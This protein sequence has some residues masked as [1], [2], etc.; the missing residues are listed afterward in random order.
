MGDSNTKQGILL[1]SGTNEVEIIE[2]YL[3]TQSF[4]VNVAKV[5][6]IVQFEDRLLTQVPKTHDAAIGSFQHR[7]S[8]IP[9][10]DLNLALERATDENEQRKLVLI[11][12][13]NRNIS[14]FL[15]DGVN[16][17]HRISWEQLQP[18]SSI[19]VHQKVPVIGS[20]RVDGREVL[21]LD[22]EEIL[23]E[24]SPGT[25]F[26]GYEDTLSQMAKNETAEDKELK[27]IIVEDSSFI[28]ES[29]L[30]NMKKCGFEH[31]NAFE[32]GKVAYE[33]LNGIK[34]KISESGQKVK[35]LINIVV[36][37]IEMPQM[38]GLSLC[39]FV[40]GDPALKEVPVV[41]FSSLIN[42]EMAR[43]CDSVG[44]DAYMT[45]PNL[46]GMIELILTHANR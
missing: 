4:G 32:N 18:M 45:K 23:A 24:V 1:E 35:E 21:I 28:R 11:S 26:A 8:T 30:A 7:E 12:E 31:V 27:I 10:I 20:V 43:K 15:I 41:L 16:R 38:D 37:D 39:K 5:K 3:G 29:I 33:Y 22:L 42:D 2:F 14:G 40:K 13:F 6:Q 19:L 34:D 44:A 9:L 36:T 46:P 17:I 25:S